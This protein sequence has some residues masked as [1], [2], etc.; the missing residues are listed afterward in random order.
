MKVSQNTFNF[1]EDGTDVL[2]EEE[3]TST[4]TVPEGTEDPLRII[5]STHY[6]QDNAQPYPL[7]IKKR[8]RAPPLPTPEYNKKER[9]SFPVTLNTNPG[10]YQPRVYRNSDICKIL[11][12]SIAKKCFF[13]ILKN[14][15]I[16]RKNTSFSKL[17]YSPVTL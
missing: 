11:F 15:L 4:K 16:L 2:P 6:H 10:P 3:A 17:F 14:G 9:P 1:Q 12:N 7:K 8:V 5:S 13:F